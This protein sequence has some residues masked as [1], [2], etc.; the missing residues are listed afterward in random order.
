MA[1]VIPITH[2]VRQPP[3]KLEQP[4]TSGSPAQNWPEKFE[5]APGWKVCGGK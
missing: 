4:G 2:S 5:T 3:D 1:S